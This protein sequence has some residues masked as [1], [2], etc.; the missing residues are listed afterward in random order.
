V[1][2]FWPS[3]LKRV[4]NIDVAICEACG[5]TDK[6]VSI[7][8]FK[9]QVLAREPGETARTPAWFKITQTNTSP[10]L[11]ASGGK[12]QVRLDLLIGN[13]QN[14]ALRPLTNSVRQIPLI[15]RDWSL[16]YQS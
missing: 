4:F 2:L 8:L 16:S 12:Q 14:A 7:A 6:V 15:E 1:A 3:I 10:S 5:G 9:G 11:V 13:K